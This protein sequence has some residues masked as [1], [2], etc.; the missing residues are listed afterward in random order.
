MWLTKMSL[1]VALAVAGVSV[2]LYSI[3]QPTTTPTIKFRGGTRY[4]ANP[5]TTTATTGTA[6]L[7]TNA[8][9]EAFHRDGFLLKKG[10][11]QGDELKELVAAGETLY[12]SWSIMDFIVKNSFAKLVFQVWREEEHFAQVAF[13]SSFPTIAAELLFGFNSNNEKE[14][15][16]HENESSSSSSETTESSSSSIRILK[17]GFF[18][19]KGKNNTGC[20]FHVDDKGFWPAAD[21]STGVNFWLALSPMR[22]SEGGGIRVVNQSISEPFAEECMAVIRDIREGGYASTCNMEELSPDCHER[23]QAAST[24]FDMEPGD[25]LIWDRWT[26]HRSEPFRIVTEEH[27]LRYTIRYVPGSA[28]AEGMLHSSQQAGET[29]EG[30][31]YSQVWPEAVKAEVD[32]IRD[33]LEGDSTFTLLLKSAATK[34]GSRFLGH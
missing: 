1:L 7:L 33:G 20:G 11:F 31:H 19:F 12:S 14:E 23:M 2:Q 4:P 18:G 10:L 17:D 5:P 15:H 6:N 25:V 27:K 22:M 26:F 16:V 30:A 9:K 28:K 21:D 34:L 8:E 29:F 32:A 13:E 24:T 3:L